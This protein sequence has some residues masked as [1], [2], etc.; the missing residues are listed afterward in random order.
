MNNSTDEVLALFSVI[1]LGLALGKIPCC[2]ISLGTS[3]VVFVALLAGHLGFEVP[4]LAGTVGIILFVYC[5]GI[6]AGPGFLRV[7]VRNGR[8][9]TVMAVAMIAAAGLTAWGMAKMLRLEADLASGLFAGA[10]TST[11]AL[12]AAAERLPGD[13]QVAVGF[14]LA[15]PIGVVGVILFVQLVPRWLPNGASQHSPDGEND[16][17][18]DGPITRVLVR[19]VNPGVA[20][21]RLRDVAILSHANC[22]ISRILIAEKMHPIPSGFQLQVGQC[23]LVVGARRRLQDVIEVLGERCEDVSYTLD[24]ERQRRRVVVTSAEMIG[25]SLEQLH[26]LS[27]FGVTISRINRHDFEFVPS[28]QER[29]QFGDALSAV[30]ESDALDRFVQFA[31]HRERSFDETDLISLAAGLLLGVL[32]GR[33]QLTLG[34]ESISLGLAGGPLLVGLL[35]GHFGQIGPVV[36]RMPRAAR[37]LLTEAGL[38]LFLARA[39]SQAGDQFLAVL[40][41]HGLTLCLAALMIVVTPL[42]V[43]LLVARIA[44]PLRIGEAL[45]GICG[46]MT[47]TPGLGAITSSMDSSVPATSYAAIYPLALILIT[48]LAPLLISQL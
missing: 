41:T 22:Q 17:S 38:A 24:L 42:I 35:L 39:G 13:S 48:L 7:F 8:S 11:P 12:A 37:F 5:L 43:G 1:G 32:V 2:G 4:Q 23:L 30:G 19:V 3:G 9:L 16:A 18:D 26:L 44:L 36:G 10:L 6:G 15:Y 27:R 45:G 29:I 33:V 40:Q 14:G 21:K 47:S 20:G 28:A 46:A 31:G 25:R 34:G